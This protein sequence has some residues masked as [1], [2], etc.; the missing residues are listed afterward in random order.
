MRHPVP[1]L[2]TLPGASLALLLL[3]ALWAQPPARVEA[4]SYFPG[5]ADFDGFPQ[6]GAANVPTDVVPIYRNPLEGFPRVG[7]VTFSLESADG[8]RVALEARAVESRTLVKWTELRPASA[9]QPNTRYTLRALAVYDQT[10]AT[11]AS[12]ESSL[13]FTTGSSA[14]SP[15]SAPGEVQL[16]HFVFGELLPG[17]CAAGPSTGTCLNLPKDVLYQVREPPPAAG[18][19][20]KLELL[21]GPSFVEQLGE[22]GRRLCVELRQRAPNGDFGPLRML[23]HDQGPLYLLG[24]PGDGQSIACTSAGM[25]LNQAPIADRLSPVPQDQWETIRPKPIGPEAGVGDAGV[26]D[27]GS[28]GGSA[29]HDAEA[30]AA[31]TTTS[32]EVGSD[33]DAVGDEEGCRLSRRQPRTVDLTLACWLAAWLLHRRRALVLAARRR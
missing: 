32:A 31:N 18:F 12:T 5:W 9:L 21:R 7:A 28:D 23:C 30:R 6:A 29:S 17:N 24:R 4:C 14:T 13:E 3:A 11:R 26:S 10:Y 27:G 16:Q 2:R 1:F 20:E 33:T 25:T 22:Y 15:L 19:G 8:T